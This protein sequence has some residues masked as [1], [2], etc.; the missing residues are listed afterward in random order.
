MLPEWITL[1][2]PELVLGECDGPNASWFRA[3]R[4]RR[5]IRLVRLFKLLRLVK[6]PM[7][8]SL[9]QRTLCTHHTIMALML[10]RVML[11]GVCV[12]HVLG[13]VWYAVGDVDRGWVSVERIATEPLN[14]RYFYSFQWALARSQPMSMSDNMKLATMA[15]KAWSVIATFLCLRVIS[16]FLSTVT[17]LMTEHHRQTSAKHDRLE[18]VREYVA[19][20]NI[21]NDLIYTLNSFPTSDDKNTKSREALWVSIMPLHVM[22]SVRFQAYAPI[23][24]AHRFFYRL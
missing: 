3:L 9:L 11:Y 2:F 5:M 8:F 20:H 1:L 22:L 16:V 12:V 23:L 15:E 24:S 21:L 7:L 10:V 6:L 18:A 17:A 4:G 19:D 13:Y 14:V